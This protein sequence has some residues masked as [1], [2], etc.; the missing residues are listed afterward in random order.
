MKVVCISD[1][2]LDPLTIGKFYDVEESNGDPPVYRIMDDQGKLNWFRSSRF[3][4][5]C[6]IRNDKLDQIGI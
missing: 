4:D 6:K 3:I 5:L 1:K 2:A